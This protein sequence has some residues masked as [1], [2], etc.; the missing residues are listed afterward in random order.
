M[1]VECEAF[2]SMEGGG[3]KLSK[4]KKKSYNFK[5]III[6]QSSGSDG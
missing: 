4:L 3:L 5:N 1:H 2:S 6:D